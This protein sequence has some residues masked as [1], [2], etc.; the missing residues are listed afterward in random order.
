M[1]PWQLLI[2]DWGDTIMRDFPDL[3]GSMAFWPRV[4]AISG[5]AEALAAL[6]PIYP[7]CLASNAGAS[8]AALMGQ[9]LERV[10]LRQYFRHLYTSKELGAAKPSPDFFLGVCQRVGVDPAACVMIGNDYAKDIAGA[11][12]VGIRTVWLAADP[13]PGPHPAAD[14][15]IATLAD[16]PGALSHLH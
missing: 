5:A 15:I 10:G 13:G 11:R 2:F 12:A 8:D 7:C 1:A 14:V 9:A 16:L 4:E 3:P 6:S